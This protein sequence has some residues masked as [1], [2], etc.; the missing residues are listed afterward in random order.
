MSTAS[1]TRSGK[2]VIEALMAGNTP[3]QKA[4]ATRLQKE[5]IAQRAA[6]GKDP[7]KVLAGLHSRVK[8]LRSEGARV[9]VGT[10]KGRAAK[11][12]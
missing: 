2:E 8:R 1:K 6:D 3:A 9:T 11:R 7:K 4:K 10:K 5:Y 12:K